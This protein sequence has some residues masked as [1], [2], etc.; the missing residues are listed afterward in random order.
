MWITNVIGG[1][2][3]GVLGQ[4]DFTT[5]SFLGSSHPSLTNNNMLVLL[6]F[7]QK[8]NLNPGE[9]RGYYELVLR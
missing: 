3:E 6:I 4:Q 5:R 2:V 1:L 9:V 8:R 7:H